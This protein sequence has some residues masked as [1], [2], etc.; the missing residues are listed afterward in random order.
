MILI[1]IHYPLC[2][3]ITKFYKYYIG[4][5]DVDVFDL[6]YIGASNWFYNSSFYLGTYYYLGILMK[7]K[8]FKWCTIY[9]TFHNLCASS[10][11]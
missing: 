8:K 4:R 3:I 10:F 9:E 2:V 1:N 6:S 11:S 7:V 5:R